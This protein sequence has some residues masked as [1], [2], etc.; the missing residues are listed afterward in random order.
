MGGNSSSCMLYANQYVYV[1]CLK[2]PEKI[3]QYIQF[4]H[5]NVYQAKQKIEN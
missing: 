2:L 4:E 5:T 1:Y 3:T